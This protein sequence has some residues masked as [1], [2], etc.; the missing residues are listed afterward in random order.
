MARLISLSVLLTLI[1]VLGITF[2]RVIA[3]FLLPLFLAGVV[4]VL[5]QP[6]FLYF[7]RRTKGRI[8][9][10]AGLST[11]VVVAA[12]LI[13]IVAGTVLG[14]L[15]LYTFAVRIADKQT[16][17]E[18]LPTSGA[19]AKSAPARFI[20]GS[21]DFINQFLAQDQKLTAEQLRE[22]AQLRLREGLK[23]LGDRSLGIAGG[24]LD[25]VTSS[26]A[27]VATAVL[28]MLIFVV[29]LYYF[30]AD[31][32]ALLAATESLIP[33][34]ADYQRQLLNQF[35][36]VVRAVVMATFMAALVQGVAT[37]LALWLTGFENLF[38][39]FI[40][41]T[42][43]SLIPMAGAW[44]IWGPC[45]V[46]LV[47][48]GQVGAAV[49]LAVYGVAV[50]GMIDNVVRTYV[51]R[52]DTKL[53]PLLAL[54]SVLGGLQ[55]LGLWGVFIGPIVASCLHALVKIFNLE[56]VELSRERLAQ[57]TLPAL[58]AGAESAAAALNPDSS[59]EGSLPSGDGVAAAQEARRQERPQ[60]S[61]SSAGVAGPTAAPASRHRT[62]KK[63]RR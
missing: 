17:D 40:L 59:L 63:R 7:V 24:T 23:K 62:K 1:V 11:G 51:L 46:I 49:L 13:P 30:Y 22:Q 2:F 43:A 47:A 61:A 6:L 9:L 41:A 35:A 39:L 56:L 58:A 33:V 57:R 28:E 52:S 27:V 3:P 31:G 44:L 15:Q 38:I 36:R 21:V 20:Q 32:T 60:P 54:I 53:H 42:V 26:V 16:W 12:L 48:R 34:Q 18:L 37:T 25:F 29:A 4:A 10:A 8:R 55:V 5:S 45:A 19:E 14:S 50:V